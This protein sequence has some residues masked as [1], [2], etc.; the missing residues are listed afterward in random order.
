VFNLELPS[1]AAHY[2]HRAG[3]TGRMGAPGVVVSVAAPGERFVVERLA[4][5]LG[6]P[7][8]VRLAGRPLALSISLALPPSGR[9]AASHPP[10]AGLC[11]PRIRRPPARFPGINSPAVPARRRRT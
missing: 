6:V 7:I 5:R 4:G 3:R 11:A 9:T 1:S 2:A 10:V 8:L